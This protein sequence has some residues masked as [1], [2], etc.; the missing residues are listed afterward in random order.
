MLRSLYHGD[1]TLTLGILGGG[2]L[3]KMLASAAYRLGLNVAIIENHSYSPAGDMTKF[4]FTNGWSNFHDL[5][6]FIDVSDIITLENEF[7]D[8]Q[9]LAYIGNKRQVFPTAETMELIQDKFVQK[10]TFKNA[11]LPLP[12]FEEINSENDAAD[13]GKKFGFP[14]VIK[15]RKY[16]YDGYGNATVFNEGSAISSYHKFNK[17]NIND[18]LMG[19]SFVEFGKELAVIV[20]RNQ[21]GDTVIY[22]TVETIQYQHICHQVIAP[23]ELELS[24]RN[25]AAK[26]ALA[27]V[28]S[29]NGI[30][31]FGVELFLTKN[32]EILINEIAPRPH[33]SG[34]YTIESCYT[35]QFENAIR[36]VCGLPLGSPEM[37]CPA[38]CMINL[39]GT[40]DGIAN[41]TDINEVL[42][43]SKV[44]L[45]L[46]NKKQSRMGRKMG[47]ITALGTSQSEAC[48][49]A[50]SASEA[51][52]W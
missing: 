10:T 13:F 25:E 29:I 34:H 20:A 5:D 26:I 23:A 15:A 35:S 2:Q 21:I 38:A 6:E 46:Y 52:I 37:I 19:E 9:I 4:D 33:N 11:G 28:N 31:V 12:N 30:G 44:F 7:I 39:L 8:P 24:L 18:L 17:D 45:H 14:Y 43:H 47:H 49:I 32:N 22:P 36:A 1:K 27:T 16:G 40:R 50:K 3:A 41:P 42:R 48:N 51:I